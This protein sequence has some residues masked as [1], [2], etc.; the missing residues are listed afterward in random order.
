[1]MRGEGKASLDPVEM[2]GRKLRGDQLAVASSHVCVRA[3]NRRSVPH[4]YHQR[5]S[6]RIS[7]IRK[8]FTRFM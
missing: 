8:T 2:S 3:L 7:T 6:A 1:M 5:Q 4:A